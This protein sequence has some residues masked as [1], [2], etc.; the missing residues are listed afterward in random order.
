VVKEH[1]GTREGT[2]KERVLP[3]FGNAEGGGGEGI[4]RG[5]ERRSPRAGFRNRKRIRSVKGKKAEEA[6]ALS[7]GGNF[8]RVWGEN[9]EALGQRK[10]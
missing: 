1:K 6:V 3:I 5:R 2:R 10:A 9:G 8:I 7:W 4:K